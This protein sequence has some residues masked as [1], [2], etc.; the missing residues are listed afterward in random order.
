MNSG[1]WGG[2]IEM[3][4]CSLMFRCNIHVYERYADYYKRISAFDYP[5]MPNERPI[6]RVLYCGG[7]HYGK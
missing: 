3:A 7:V 5:D 1:T 2:G 4:C 6:I